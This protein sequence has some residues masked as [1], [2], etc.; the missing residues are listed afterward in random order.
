VEQLANSLSNNSPEVVK[1]FMEGFDKRLTASGNLQLPQSSWETQQFLE[2]AQEPKK[3]EELQKTEPTP[4]PDE[5]Q[6][7]KKVHSSI[8]YKE[9]WFTANHLGISGRRSQG[10]R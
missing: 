3:S 4:A 1:E 9:H 5:E 10:T 2:A 6:Q 8:S 7:R